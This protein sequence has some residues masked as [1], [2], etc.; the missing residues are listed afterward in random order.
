MAGCP[1][2]LPRLG[3]CGRL[4]LIEISVAITDNRTIIPAGMDPIWPAQ[5]GPFLQ[6]VKDIISNAMLEEGEVPPQYGNKG[7]GVEIAYQLNDDGWEE[8]SRLDF[9]D[10]TPTCPTVRCNSE[11]SWYCIRKERFYG[12]GPGDYIVVLDWALTGK[13]EILS[14]AEPVEDACLWKDRECI[15]LTSGSF[16][17]CEN[18]DLDFQAYCVLHDDTLD[19]SNFDSANWYLGY[20]DS[21]Q[22]DYRY[23]S[24]NQFGDSDGIP[25]VAPPID[26]PGCCEP[27]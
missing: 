8:T 17:E 25:T 13:A 6:E 12:G 11:I 10:D 3:C 23:R 20:A 1:A 2:W 22:F 5:I 19:F 15:G 26:L 24:L 16:P 21:K 27:P 9:I 4:C 18:D 14:L 7:R